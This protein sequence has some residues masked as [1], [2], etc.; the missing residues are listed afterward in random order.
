MID[1][2]IVLITGASSGIGLVTAVQLAEQGHIVYA[3]SRRGNSSV[4]L[5]NLHFVQADVNDKEQMKHIIELITTNNQ[6]IDVVICNAGNG[7]AGAIEDCAIDE[8][9][10]QME[11]N[12]FGVVN[13]IQQCLPYLREQKTGK[14]IVISSL[15]AIFPI[16]YQ[17]FYAASKAAAHI[18]T[19]ALSIEVKRFNIQVCSILPGDTKTNFTKARSFAKQAQSPTSVYKE[20]MLASVAK[21]EHDELN[22][23]KPEKVAKIIVNQVQAKKMGKVIIPGISNKLLYGLA[24]ILPNKVLLA[25]LHKMYN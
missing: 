24:H 16:P 1:Q 13:T 9:R 6:K 12:F 19:Q 18:L 11:T 14:I 2:K 25:L 4:N 22:G 20:K 15:A 17:A 23:M 7:I 10:F 5:P 8:I 3:T 21:M